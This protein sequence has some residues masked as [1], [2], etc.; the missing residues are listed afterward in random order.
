M[1]FAFCWLVKC[2]LGWGSHGQVVGSCCR[3]G[4]AGMLG[5]GPMPAVEKGRGGHGRWEQRDRIAVEL[6]DFGLKIYRGHKATPIPALQLPLPHSQYPPLCH[7]P[8]IY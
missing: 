5:W 6:R 3:E 7:L 8:N 1:T 4:E 2:G